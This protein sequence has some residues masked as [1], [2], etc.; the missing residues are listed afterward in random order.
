MIAPPPRAEALLEALGAEHGYRDAVIGDLAE[1]FQVRAERDGERAARWW[2]YGEAVRSVPTL[3]RSWGRSLRGRDFAHLAGLALTAFVLSRVVVGLIIGM[4]YIVAL[5][6]GGATAAGGMSGI[7]FMI[8]ALKLALMFADALV[9]GF[10]AA[11]LHERA[12]LTSAFALGVLWS[13]LSVGALGA[14]WSFGLVPTGARYTLVQIGMALGGMAFTII[15]TTL[16]GVLRVITRRTNAVD[17][18]LA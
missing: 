1:E 11:W 8:I 7:V 4:A 16:G 18:R 17:A 14:L 9:A 3:A 12:P 2:Y 5:R 15:G 13:L 6:T 10:V